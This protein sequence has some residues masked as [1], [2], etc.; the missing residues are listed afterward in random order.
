MGVSTY[1]I[2]WVLWLAETRQTPRGV[3]YW[4]PTDDDVSDFVKTK[5]DVLIAENERLRLAQ[6]GTYNQG[7][8]YLFGMPTYWR[9]L[10]SKSGVKSISG[11]AAIYDEFDEADQSQLKQAR[12]RLSFSALKWERELSTPT[13]PD[14]GINKRFQETDQQHFGFK[15]EGCGRWNILEDLFPRCFQQD[16]EG[17][18]Y[19]ACSKCHHALNIRDGQWICKT[20]SDLRGY[21]I[22]QLYSPFISPNEIMR[23][24][25]STEFMG[26]FY[27]HVIGK[28]YLSATDMVN[29]E[30]VLGLCDPLKQMATNYLKPTVMGIDVGSLLHCTILEP[31]D[32]QRVIWCGEIKQFEELDTIMLKFNV[33][34]VV[35]DALPETRKVREFIA[36]HKHKAWMCFYMDHQKG[37]Y[38]WNEETR[39]VSVNR[40]E[41]LDYGTDAMI[42]K[43]MV[44]P[45]RSDMIERFAAHCGNVAKVVEDKG[46]DRRYVYKKIGPDHFRHSLNYAQI[47]ATRM[48]NGLAF[49]VFR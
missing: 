7:L 48:R 14:F 49:S 4:L 22:S 47:A 9:G 17:N 3:L 6:S 13:I 1:C 34:E 43:K 38:A 25:Q 20:R 31:G 10:K 46:G 11:D 39:Q 41:S 2:L 21:H 30:T 40:T 36:R 32:P 24:Y 18:Y 8:K 35:I 15:C 29:A 12:Q 5:L 26:H 19:H 16:R 28:P 44:L 37:S 27:N 45:Q 23:E 33:R 42:K